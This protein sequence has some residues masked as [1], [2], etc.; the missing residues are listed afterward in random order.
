MD[1]GQDPAAE[2]VMSLPT[3]PYLDE[4][5]AQQIIQAVA[6]GIERNAQR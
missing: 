4:E 1:A 3:H 6:Q 5:V 2:E